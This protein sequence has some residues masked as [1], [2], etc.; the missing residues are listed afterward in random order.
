[1]GELL[2]LFV[3]HLEW[4]IRQGV[5]SPVLFNVY[6]NVIGNSIQ[7]SKQGCELYGEYIG[8]FGQMTL[9]YC[10]PQ[11][12]CHKKMFLKCSPISPKGL[13]ID[14]VFN[15]KKSTLF[16]VGKMCDVE[17]GCLQIGD[18]YIS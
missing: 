3:H 2:L 13:E 18:N 5:L 4:R 9:F 1:M 17:I 10:Q 14:V 12:L 16:V 6:F 7:H 11:L 8:C 15:A